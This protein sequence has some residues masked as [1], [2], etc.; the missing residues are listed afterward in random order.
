MNLGSLKLTPPYVDK[1]WKIF[2]MVKEWNDHITSIS[3]ASWVI[4]LNKSMSIWHSR[5]TCPGWVFCPWNPHPFWNECHTSCCALS[6]IFI[7]ELVEIKAHPLQA[8]PLEFE[9]FGGNTVGLLLRMRKSYFFTGRYVIVD[10]SFFVFKGLI[11][12]RKEGI[13]SCAFIKKRR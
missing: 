4:C 9:D 2:Y 13:F 1:F 12:L 3:L 7:V 6:W 10:Y 5:W 11:Q 8:V